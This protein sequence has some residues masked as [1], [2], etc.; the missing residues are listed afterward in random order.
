MSNPSAN[1]GVSA[2][3]TVGGNTGNVDR[4][5][6][7]GLVPGQSGDYASNADMPARKSSEKCSSMSTML[8][9]HK[10]LMYRNAAAK[11]M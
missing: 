9:Q 6:I 1:T 2:I 3:S 11:H 8:S 7:G 5:S 4:P 10:Y